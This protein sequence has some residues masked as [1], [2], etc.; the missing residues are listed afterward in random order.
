MLK[1][2]GLYLSVVSLIL[3]LAT[4]DVLA[5]SRINFRRGSNS[6]SVSGTIPANGVRSYV[7]RARRGQSLTATLSSG[8]GRVD[9]TQ[10]SLHDSQFSRVLER[11]GDVYI[12]IDNHGNR[13][14][15]FTL[16]VSIQ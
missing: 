1:K 7:L 15:R 10:G 9:F 3:V 5:Q 8:N 2:I 4:S 13:S 14:T 16:T 6:A 11:N 12:D